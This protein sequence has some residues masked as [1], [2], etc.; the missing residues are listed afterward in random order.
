MKLRFLF[1]ISSL[2]VLSQWGC[3][4]DSSP[5]WIYCQE[6]GADQWVG[7]YNGKGDYY[8]NSDSSN[9]VNIET[10]LEIEKLYGNVL[11]ISVVAQDVYQ[12]S[13]TASK[14]D[15]EYFINMPGSGKSLYLTLTQ[16][17]D[18]YRVTGVTKVYHWKYAADTTLVIDH[19]LGFEVVRSE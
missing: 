5:N 2:L 14:D 3:K 8:K 16:S 4:K 13:F 18:Q 15:N 11:S 19:R 9:V 6:C 1:V 7:T 12:T 17:G 10:R